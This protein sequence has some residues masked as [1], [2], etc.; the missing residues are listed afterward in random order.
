MNTKESLS[1]ALL[2][3]SS[4]NAIAQSV[5]EEPAAIVEPGGAA[6]H[7]LEDGGSS[8]GFDLAAETAPI[9]NWLELE[10]RYLSHRLL[11]AQKRTRRALSRSMK[12]QSENFAVDDF[13][14]VGSLQV[15]NH[16]TRRN[17]MPTTT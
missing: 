3:L 12:R 17:R 8:F 1:L 5:D 13:V 4:G 7:G 10:G 2:F 16:S 6:S 14:A 9:K 11:G 15:P